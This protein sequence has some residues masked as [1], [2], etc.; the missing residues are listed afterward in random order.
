[1]F[2]G[3]VKYVFVLS[4]F[5]SIQVYSQS[6]PVTFHYKPS[7]QGFTTVRLAGSFE[8]WSIT[9]PNYIMHDINSDGIYEITTKINPGTYQY[10]F[11]VD[12][13]Y[14]PDPDNPVFDGSQYMNSQ[15]V[16]TDPMVTYLQPSDTS[17]YSPS[18]LPHLRAVFAFNPP[19]DASSPVFTLKINGQS[20]SP[21][22]AYY[23]T[24]TKT[25]DYP[26]SPGIVY[27]GIDTL[28]VGIIVQGRFSTK[29]TK[30]KVAA[31]PRF[32][33]LTEEY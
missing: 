20:I 7:V 29:A 31:D 10:K 21:L 28:Q 5:F 26:L 14:F 23:D 11:V 2:S 27:V 17:T 8:G 13:A 16:V 6:V 15:I 33:L 25:L 3:I 30:I 32:D 9:D 24:T 4:V 19:T 12:G 1:M 18:T 22:S